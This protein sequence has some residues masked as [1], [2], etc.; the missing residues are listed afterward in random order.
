MKGNSGRDY[1]HRMIY[2]PEGTVITDGRIMA[3]LPSEEG[4]EEEI[5]KPIK[6]LMAVIEEE[7]ELTEKTTTISRADLEKNAK[8]CVANFVEFA[9]GSV[10]GKNGLNLLAKLAKEEAAEAVSVK[11][12]EGTMNCLAAYFAK[13]KMVFVIPPLPTSVHKFIATEQSFEQMV[14]DF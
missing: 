2:S 3:I 8:A 7:E 4:G 6:M 12:I 1:C 14:F 11:R 13:I 10:I 5:P 9:D